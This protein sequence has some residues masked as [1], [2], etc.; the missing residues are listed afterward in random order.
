MWLGLNGEGSCLLHP[1]SSGAAWLRATGPASK[2]AYLRGWQIGSGCWLGGQSELRAQD[3]GFSPHE[4]LHETGLPHN[5]VA[6]RASSPRVTEPGDRLHVLLWP[7]LDS[8]TAYH[9]HTAFVE[10]VT[11]ACLG[12]KGEDHLLLMAEQQGS[13]WGCHM[14]LETLLSHLYKYNR[15]QV[16]TYV[17]TF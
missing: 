6:P 12:S 10:V 2:K 9:L 16:F 1:E 7:S 5:M 14:G 17:K 11:K 13:W 4:P 3:L 8:H 15:L